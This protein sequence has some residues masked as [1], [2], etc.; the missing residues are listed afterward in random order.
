M[1][2]LKQENLDTKFEELFQKIS[3][4]SFLRMEALGGEIPFFI[5]T[6]NPA[7]QVEVDKHI[8]SLKNRLMNSGIEVF[9]IN[10]YDISLQI[11]SERGL[12][13]KLLD[14]ESSMSKSRFLQNIQGPLDV[15][16]NLVP[17]I[18]AEVN[19]Q[20]CK[21]VFITG[22]GLVYPYMRSHTVLNNLQSVLK[23]V[24]TIIFFP[25]IYTGQSL[26]LFGKL[27]DDNYYRAFNLDK[28]KG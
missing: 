6:Y 23:E 24:P 27:K 22:V 9:E 28:I 5:T 25:G 17:A 16:K 13:Q 10:L 26:E 19:S 4:P 1:E 8:G 18:A 12:L 2:L 7:Q 3:K 20:T 21:L 15:E 11:L 14:K